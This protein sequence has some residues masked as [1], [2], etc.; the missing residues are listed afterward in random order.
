M[1]YC[2]FW[3]LDSDHDLTID[4]EALMRYDNYAL[5]SRVVERIMMGCGLG[6]S[7]AKGTRASDLKMTYREFICK[8]KTPITCK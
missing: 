2:K 7:V 8:L 3:E 1:I 6:K 4:V 5:S